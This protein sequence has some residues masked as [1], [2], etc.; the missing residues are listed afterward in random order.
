MT[1]GR[2]TGESKGCVLAG[3]Q[4][5]RLYSGFHGRELW[6][7]ERELGRHRLHPR[8]GWKFDV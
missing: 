7:V 2:G 4:V 6:M 1:K 8:R 3:E 5:V